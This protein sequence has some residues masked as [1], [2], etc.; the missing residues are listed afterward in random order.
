M[1][2]VLPFQG[3]RYGPPYARAAVFSPPYDVIGPALRAR[4]AAQNAHNVVHVDLRPAFADDGWYAEAAA[5]LAGWIEA[6]VLQRDPAP[7]FYGYRQS[8]RL[9]GTP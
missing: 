6:G 2:E 7:C 4:L 8:F 3:L 9:P 1:V 5:T